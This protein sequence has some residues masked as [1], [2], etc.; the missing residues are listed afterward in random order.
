MDPVAA[1]AGAAAKAANTIA[2][3]ASREN[4]ILAEVAQAAGALEPAAHDYAQRLAIKQEFYLKMWQPL[5]QLFNLSREYFESGKFE[6]EMTDRL[7][8]IPDENVVTPPLSIAGPVVQGISYT[9]DEPELR[10]MYLNLLATASD[11]RAASSAHPAFAEVIRQLAGDEVEPLGVLLSGENNPIAE[12]RLPI[13]AADQS[14][15]PSYN[16]LSTHLLPLATTDGITYDERFAPFV[17]NWQRLGLMTTSYDHSIA[18]AR[19][20]EWVEEHPV[21][22]RLSR[23]HGRDS[24]EIQHGLLRRTEFGALF[25]RVVVQPTRQQEEPKADT[26]NAEAD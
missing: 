21:T 2:Q 15:T 8:D 6:E 19:R 7:K 10:A 20:Y 25:W 12:V 13:K 4:Q 5:A 18:N 26:R 11:D 9:V 23:Q 3:G 14:N 22:L 17:D 16:V 1:G 24:I